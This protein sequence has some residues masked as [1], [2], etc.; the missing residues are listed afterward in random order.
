MANHSA[1]QPHGFLTHE[2][3]ASW[4]SM[5]KTSD[6]TYTATQGHERIPENWYRRKSDSSSRNARKPPT[7]PIPTGALAYPYEN[8]YFLADAANAIALYPKFVNIGGNTGT[9][10]SF[11]RVKRNHTWSILTISLRRASMFKTFPAASSTEGI[12]SKE[13]T[14]PAWPT[15]SPHK[16]SP[17]LSSAH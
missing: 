1:S 2:V 6:G 13:I 5:T 16:L 14:S 17:I 9:P 4:F 15:N 11:V 10:N 3:L 8:A 7:K 12:F